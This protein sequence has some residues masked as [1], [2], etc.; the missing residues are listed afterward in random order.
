MNRISA[1]VTPPSQRSKLPNFD[2]CLYAVSIGGHNKPIEDVLQGYRWA[3]GHFKRC[4]ILLGDSLYRFT[5]QIQRGSNPK[6]AKQIAYKAGQLTLDQIVSQMTRLPEVIRTSD[7]LTHARFKEYQ[8]EVQALYD[9][10][11]EFL[12]SVQ[13][14]AQVFVRRQATRGR[15]ALSEAE[16]IDLAAAYLLEEIAIYGCLAE[17]GWLVDVYLGSELPSLQRFITGELSGTSA[18]LHKRVNV[19]LRIR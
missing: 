8:E 4:G 19:A 3:I 12:N 14:D 5:V 13:A 18:P 2:R 16:A 6:A 7:M 10:K 15:L 1:S 9:T 11:Q 17:E